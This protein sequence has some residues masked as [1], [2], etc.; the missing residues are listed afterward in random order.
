MGGSQLSNQYILFTDPNLVIQHGDAS[1]QPNFI[2]MALENDQGTYEQYQAAPATMKSILAEYLDPTLD[3]GPIIEYQNVIYTES[4]GTTIITA[5]DAARIQGKFAEIDQQF[6]DTDVTPP[7][8]EH[9]RMN[10]D[11][12]N[13][14][15]TYFEAEAF[16][17]SEVS[18]L[19]HD[20]Q[21]LKAQLEQKESLTKYQPYDNELQDEINKLKGQIGN[22]SAQ[23]ERAQQA[24]T[25]LSDWFAQATASIVQD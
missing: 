15:L 4:A 17:K 10:T 7:T 18:Q 21:G 6:D 12:N 14:M 8:L 16:L 20:L 25:D 11:P 2:G 3:D 13:Q 19:K 1:G 9:G 5:D 24:L 23:L 22:V